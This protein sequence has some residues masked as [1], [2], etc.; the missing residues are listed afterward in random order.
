VEGRERVVGAALEEDELAE[1]VAVDRRRDGG[2]VGPG[3]GRAGQGVEVAG[4]WRERGRRRRLDAARGCEADHREGVSGGV[5]EQ[6][7]ALAEDVALRPQASLA[8]RVGER[9][10]RAGW[11]YMHLHDLRARLGGGLGGGDDLGLLR[12][13]RRAAARAAAETERQD[14]DHRDESCVQRPHP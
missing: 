2:A 5:F 13:T 11:W 8:G 12:R 7:G 4:A 3:A 10:R 1:R 14:D 6:R 9:W